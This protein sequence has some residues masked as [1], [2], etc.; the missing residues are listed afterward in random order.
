LAGSRGP[1]KGGFNYVVIGE[2]IARSIYG[3]RCRVWVIQSSS[4][5]NF[6]WETTVFYSCLADLLSKKH[7]T[8]FARKLPLLRCSIS[9]SLATAFCYLGHQGYAA[10]LL[11]AWSTP[12]SLLSWSLP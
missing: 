5:L 1:N 10:E 3:G 8:Y 12:L 2:E 7:G 11:N 6:W 9:F 4:F